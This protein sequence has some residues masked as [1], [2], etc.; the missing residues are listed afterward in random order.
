MLDAA[1]MQRSG[2]EVDLFPTQIPNFG[3]TQSVAECGEDHQCIARALP[4]SAG[5]L[6]QL[7]DL[8]NR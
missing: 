8:T 3:C 5:A 2:G 7:L 4:I 1:N 6:D